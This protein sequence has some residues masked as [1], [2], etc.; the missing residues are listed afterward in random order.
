MLQSEIGTVYRLNYP[1]FWGYSHQI[2]WVILMR[3]G[4]FSMHKHR[5]RPI[6]SHGEIQYAL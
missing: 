2:D 1:L 6:F 3:F 4:Y 5:F